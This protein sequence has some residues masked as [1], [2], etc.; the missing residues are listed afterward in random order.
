MILK[1]I[2][3]VKVKFEGNIS[4]D[5]QCNSTA[6]SYDPCDGNQICSKL[7][8]LAVVNRLVEVYE[9]ID[10]ELSPGIHGVR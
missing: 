5:K 1:T 6:N 8:E 9:K 7:H 2:L 4:E 3:D 10:C